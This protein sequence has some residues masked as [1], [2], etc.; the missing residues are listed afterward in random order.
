MAGKNADEIVH[1]MPDWIKYVHEAQNW[2]YWRFEKNEL[3]LTGTELK[4]K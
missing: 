4:E 2:H 1:V 3:E